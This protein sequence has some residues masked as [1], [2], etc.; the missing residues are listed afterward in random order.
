MIS[1]FDAIIKKAHAG[2]IRKQNNLTVHVSAVMTCHV[3]ALR[4][5]HYYLNLKTHFHHGQGFQN[6][7]LTLPP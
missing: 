1:A 5:I 7:D 6:L 4:L 3:M 2:K